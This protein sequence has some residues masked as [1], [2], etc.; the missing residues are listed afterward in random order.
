[1]V[2]TLGRSKKPSK[3]CWTSNQIILVS[4]SFER[5]II[6]WIDR[7]IPVVVE[8]GDDGGIHELDSVFYWYHPDHSSIEMILVFRVRSMGSSLLRVDQQLHTYLPSHPSSQI[9]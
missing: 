7:C 1:M 2:A 9:Q 8:R 6:E 5:E 3:S 4:M